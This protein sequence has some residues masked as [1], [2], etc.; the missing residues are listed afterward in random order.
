MFCNICFID[1]FANR[2]LSG[3]AKS[4]TGRLYSRD[5]DSIV[6]NDILALSFALFNRHLSNHNFNLSA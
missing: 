1:K 2:S 4:G 3:H 5:Y 6:F